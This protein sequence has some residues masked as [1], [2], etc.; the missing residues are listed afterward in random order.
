[1]LRAY[2]AEPT[3]R[4]APSPWRCTTSEDCGVSF[5]ATAPYARR[6]G[7]AADVMPRV[8]LDAQE[9]AASRV[10][11]GHR[12]RREALRA[13][14]YRPSPTCSCGSGS[15][16]CL[17]RTRAPRRV[18]RALTLAAVLAATLAGA[19]GALAT[20]TQTQRLSIGEIRLSV[21]P[22]HKGALDL[23]VPLVDWGARFESIRLPAR[24]RVDVRT[25]DRRTVARLAQGGQLDV[26]DVR[27][28]A[29]NAI[30]AYLMDLIGVVM[31][32][33]AA[34]GALVALAVRGGAGPRLRW[35]MGVVAGVSLVIGGGLIGGCLREAR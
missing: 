2:K 12:P 21:S 26:H 17:D 20:Y 13:L 25:V 3:G 29:R 33:A 24:L 4:P 1:M 9:A 19:Y 34:A 10:A 35:T 18:R 31:F 27:D 11:A 15:R 8:A 6:K 23:Y 28:E 22:G 14:G 32:A 7:L 5:V 16:A 30:K